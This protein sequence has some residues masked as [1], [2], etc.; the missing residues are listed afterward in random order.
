[1]DQNN[2]LTDALARIKTWAKKNAPN[3][4]FQP[5]AD[6]AAI[7]I[8]VQKSGLALPSELLQY[9]SVMDGEPSKSAGMIGNWRLM[10]ITEIQS[11]WGWLTRTTEK[12]AFTGQ[13]AQTS[14]YIRPAWWHPGWIPFVSSDADDYFCIDSD[15]PEPERF[16]QVILYLQGRPERLLVAGDLNSWFE[17]IARDL[18]AGV[19]TYDVINGFDGEALMWSS[20]EGKHIFDNNP[21]KLIT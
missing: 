10:P 4:T 2:P 14:P 6:P 1:M 20:L 17:R 16:G 12:G 3:V 11:A 9:L 7:E 8:F 5:P 18:E 21:G 15:P 19:Y 13:T